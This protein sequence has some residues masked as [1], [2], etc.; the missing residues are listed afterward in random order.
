MA[1]NFYKAILEKEVI[2]SPLR[3]I[4]LPETWQQYPLTEVDTLFGDYEIQ[5][6]KERWPFNEAIEVDTTK[7]T[8]PR[9]WQERSR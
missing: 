7:Q 4:L 1:E 6:L 5:I 3:P 8:C 2:K 9:P